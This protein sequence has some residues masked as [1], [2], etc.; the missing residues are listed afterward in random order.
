[1]SS[2][3]GISW[4]P[5]PALL[6]VLTPWAGAHMPL[7]P[8]WVGGPPAT[9]SGIPCH[10]LP[11]CGSPRRPSGGH[12]DG[13]FAKEGKARGWQVWLSAQAGEDQPRAWAWACPSPC[14]QRA[15]LRPW[16]SARASLTP[17]AAGA[18]W[19]SSVFMLSDQVH[20]GKRC[21]GRRC[22]LFLCGF[23]GITQHPQWS[24]ENNSAAPWPSRTVTL[25]LGH[26]PCAALGAVPSQSPARPGASW[27][28]RMVRAYGHIRLSSGP[29]A[30]LPLQSH[31]PLLRPVTTVSARPPPRAPQRWGKALPRWHV[32]RGPA[33]G[34]WEGLACE[35]PVSSEAPAGQCRDG[36]L[37]GEHGSS[38]SWSEPLLCTQ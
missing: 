1:M 19:V 25:A 28:R 38:G 6:S 12:G 34:R 15:P 30:W 13:A 21:P 32:P 5:C 3:L 20:A 14:A 29:R 7:R 2:P 10:P 36:R 31:H 9:P 11:R 33:R 22:G 24:P 16:A 4:R 37:V 17:R 26:V 27:R 35:A 23:R 18:N 8:S